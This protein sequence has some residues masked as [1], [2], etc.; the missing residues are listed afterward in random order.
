MMLGAPNERFI[1]YSFLLCIFCPHFLLFFLLYFPR[2]F[3]AL[4]LKPFSRPGEENQ[5]ATTGS[6]SLISAAAGEIRQTAYVCDAQT[7]GDNRHRV[8]K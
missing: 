8:S 1:F 6:G 7:A 3:S 5:N 4:E 2:C